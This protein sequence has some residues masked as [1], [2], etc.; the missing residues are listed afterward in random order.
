MTVPIFV[1][2]GGQRDNIG[3][4]VL[5]RAFLDSLREA[6]QLHVTAGQAPASYVSGLRLQDD[7]V[8]YEDRK[9]WRSASLRSLKRERTAWA[10]HTGELTM[11]GPVVRSYLTLGPMIAALRLA[12]GVGIHSGL[13]LR[14]ATSTRLADKVGA[15]CVGLA[16][17][18]CSVITW[19]DHPSAARARVGDIQPDWAFMPPSSVS[20]AVD[21]VRNLL[22]VAL[23]HDRPSPSPQYVEAVT[24]F[25]HERRLEIVM[26][27]Q[28]ERDLIPAR[29][30]ADRFGARV[31]EWHTSDL[32]E[33]EDRLRSLYRQT[34]FA[35]SNRLHGLVIAGTEGAT[36]VGITIG[37]AEKLD[38][39][40]EAA[41]IP[42]RGMDSVGRTSDE[43]YLHLIASAEAAP[44]VRD[45]F[46][47]AGERL[48]ALSRT[49]VATISPGSRDGYSTPAT[50][51]EGSL[52]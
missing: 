35:I 21:T 18:P 42:T 24:R 2:V 46:D 26:A 12:G 13:G 20:S 33:A 52:S 32:A 8:L 48:R 19:R 28:T 5:R 15:A 6:G 41:D 50:S 45:A 23:R 39:T 9:S 3:D 51:T 44:R 25:A 40:L 29:E 1:A 11:S 36:P 37:E 4:T 43:I 16:I 27:A 14:T 22:T 38:R 47:E 34:A 17:R 49:I 10:F 31:A 7:D 30:N